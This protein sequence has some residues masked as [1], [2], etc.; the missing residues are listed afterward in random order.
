MNI[1]DFTSHD[2]IGSRFLAVAAIPKFKDDFFNSR[3]LI[4]DVQSTWNLYLFFNAR[5]LRQPVGFLIFDEVSR[6]N[7]CAGFLIFG[8]TGNRIVELKLHS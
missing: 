4:R 7:C 5:P 1:P 6:A 8:N 2:F 3:F